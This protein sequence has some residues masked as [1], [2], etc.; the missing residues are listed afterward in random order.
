MNIT[1]ITPCTAFAGKKC[2]AAGSLEHVAPICKA[3]LDCDPHASV[4]IFDDATGKTVEMDYR[5]RK[6]TRLN[7]SH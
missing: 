7:S 1:R 2:I 6:S 4:L 3:L 5:D